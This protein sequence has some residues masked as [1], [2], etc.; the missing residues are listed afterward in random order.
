MKCDQIDRKTIK[1]W[2]NVRE[3]QKRE[4]GKFWH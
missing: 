3:I 2:Y 1:L 4:K